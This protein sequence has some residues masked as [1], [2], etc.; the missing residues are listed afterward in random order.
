VFRAV[1]DRCDALLAQER[2]ASLLDVMFGRPAATGE[3]GDTAWEQPALYA[4]ECP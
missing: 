2:G 1:L 3:L 4:L